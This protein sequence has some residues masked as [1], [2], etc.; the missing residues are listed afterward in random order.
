VSKLRRDMV[1]SV[2]AM[3]SECAL[4]KLFVAEVALNACEAGESVFIALEIDAYD[5][6]ALAQET[7][8]EH[9]AKK[10][11]TTGDEDV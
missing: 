9:A 1:D 7:P 6:V 2:K 4:K 5:S 8:F 11:R 10:A 3:L